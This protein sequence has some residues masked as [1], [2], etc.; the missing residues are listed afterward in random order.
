MTARS[1][2]E[3]AGESAAFAIP[4]LL[5]RLPVPVVVTDRE[6]RIRICNRCFADAAGHAAGALEGRYLWEFLSGERLPEARRHVAAG[7]PEPQPSWNLL[8]EHP[9]GGC[10]LAAWSFRQAGG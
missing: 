10:R 3:P 1:D 2:K 8:L 5:D 9:A 4:Q 6:G 7:A